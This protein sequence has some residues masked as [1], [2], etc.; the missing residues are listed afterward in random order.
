MLKGSFRDGTIRAWTLG[1]LAALVAACGGQ[2]PLEQEP[3]L[4]D[5]Q[6]KGGD[7]ETCDPSLYPCGPYGYQT[8][9]VIE[10]LSIS[11]RRNATGPIRTLSL[12]DYFQD[13]ITD[14]IIV[15]AS[16]EW[17]DPCKMEQA[18]LRQMYETHRG[19]LAIFQAMIQD[20]NGRPANMDVADRW[21]AQFRL[22]F[23]VG[24]DPSNMLRPYYDINAFPMNMVI[25]KRDMKITWQRNGLA[26]DELRRVV[27]QV[28]NE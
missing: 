24:V 2:T 21:A 10:N 17:C 28:L 8:G 23:D 5:E 1:S 19:R 27:G 20:L 14:A 6:G 26:E 12:A 22:N 7:R 3:I 15:T 25:R 9:A 18:G 4:P 13:S 16:A 11:G